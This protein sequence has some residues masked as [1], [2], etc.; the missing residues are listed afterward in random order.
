LSCYEAASCAVHVC[1][2]QCC[3]A[4]M[5]LHMIHTSPTSGTTDHPPPAAFAWMCLCLCFCCVQLVAAMSQ[6]QRQARRST[7]TRLRHLH[8]RHALMWLLTTA[9]HASSRWA[10]AAMLCTAYCDTAA[11]ALHLCWGSM[12]CKVWFHS[13]PV[14]VQNT[15]L[16]APAALCTLEVCLLACTHGTH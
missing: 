7:P 4:G 6:I 2:V 1:S 5:F 14:E 3:T 10:I 16:K 8:L 13:A 11:A 15:Q 12:M 9:S